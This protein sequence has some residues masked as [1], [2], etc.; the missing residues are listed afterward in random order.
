[1]SQSVTD[2]ISTIQIRDRVA[3]ILITEE[4][5]PAASS[6]SLEEFVA[7]YRRM[8]QNEPTPPRVTNNLAEFQGWLKEIRH[9]G[10]G[11]LFHRT[12]VDDVSICVHYHF[13]G[14]KQYAALYGYTLVNHSHR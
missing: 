3:G 1:M 8:L 4:I 9:K 10:G 13:G 11:G 2:T 7:K 5:K 14:P 6:L 12:C